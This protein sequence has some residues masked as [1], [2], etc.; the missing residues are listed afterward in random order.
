[1]HPR[2]HT[3]IILTRSAEQAAPL[4]ERLRAL[5]AEPLICPTIA[6]APPLDSAPLD[7][8]LRHLA[9]YDWLVFT[10]TQAVRAVWER[11]HV[12]STQTP[13]QRATP[14]D[15]M[16][17]IAAVGKGTAAALH[18]YAWRADLVADQQHGSGLAQ[19]FGAVVGQRILLPQADIGRT[20]LAERLREQGALVDTL[21]AYRTVPGPGAVRAWELLRAGHADA[22]VFSSPSTLM[23]LL[24]AMPADAT[25]DLLRQVAL[26]CIGPTTAAA[27]RTHGLDVRA[28]AAEPSVDGLLAA[29][30]AAGIVRLS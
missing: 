8:V 26:V 18:A 4:A 25:L 19:A 20:E 27:L 28:V 2:T 5:G 1:M 6:F 23:Y 16:Q 22:V 24:E 12:L 13:E 30:S 9:D 7:A 10:S 3:R 14:S 29:L 21:I 11:L 17:R 15:P